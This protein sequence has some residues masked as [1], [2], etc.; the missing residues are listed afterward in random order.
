MALSIG[1]FINIVLSLTQM[2]RNR[3]SAVSAL[4]AMSVSILTGIIVDL[5]L[6]VTGAYVP[7]AKLGLGYEVS[8]DPVSFVLMHAL[9]TII[10]AVA[11]LIY[12]KMREM[13]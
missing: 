3:L 13:I 5:L 9:M 10:G 2:A 11:G 7:I 6:F 12:R 4:A 8:V 1:M